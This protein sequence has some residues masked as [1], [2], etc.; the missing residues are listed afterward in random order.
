[1]SLP[2]QMWLILKNWSK[3]R[4]AL[5]SCLG[6]QR[7]GPEPQTPAELRSSEMNPNIL[8][9]RV[10]PSDPQKLLIL[11]CSLIGCGGLI[12]SS[13]IRTD[14]WRPGYRRCSSCS[15]QGS[16]CPA[17]AQSCGSAAGTLSRLQNNDYQNHQLTFRNNTSR[18]TPSDYSVS[19]RLLSI[20]SK[21]LQTCQE[22]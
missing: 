4:R 15:T 22:R 8:R 16:C 17:T 2:L 21:A 12:E 19:Q 9:Q 13:P 14:P 10:F 7:F 20:F 1:M 5:K 11:K 3:I 18:L 6:R